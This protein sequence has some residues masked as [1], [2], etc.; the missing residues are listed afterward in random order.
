[1]FRPEYLVSPT[2][3]YQAGRR[4]L[5][6]GANYLLEQLL[7]HSRPTGNNT[8]DVLAALDLNFPLNPE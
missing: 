7:K 1:M 4:G 8:G 5:E 2:G 3:V 6:K